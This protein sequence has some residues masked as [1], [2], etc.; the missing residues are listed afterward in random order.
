MTI[1]TNR[2]TLLHV[3]STIF[4][5]YSDIASSSLH[6]VL[7]SLWQYVLVSLKISV[8]MITPSLW[9][10]AMIGAMV[11]ASSQNCTG[12]ISKQSCTNVDKCG[13][14]SRKDCLYSSRYC[15]VGEREGQLSRKFSTVPLWHLVVA[16]QSGRMHMPSLF[17][18]VQC[19]DT[20]STLY[21]PDKS[22]AWVV[23]LS[24]SHGEDPQ[25]VKRG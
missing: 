23:A 20:A 22:L 10:A 25:D 4:I 5:N 14:V 1:N 13:F 9:V 6:L 18:G 15:L 7:W 24:T 12:S 16:Q 19:P 2:Y 8:R 17:Q 11:L 21:L 3:K